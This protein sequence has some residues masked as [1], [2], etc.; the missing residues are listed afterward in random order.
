LLVLA[1]VSPGNPYPAAGSAPRELDGGP[2]KMPGYQSHLFCASSGPPSPRV[3]AVV[4]SQ[5]SQALPVYVFEVDPK[6]HPTCE[7]EGRS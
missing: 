3:V 6:A 2:V 4:L 5:G 7:D 1:A